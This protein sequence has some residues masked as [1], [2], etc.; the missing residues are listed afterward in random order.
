MYYIYHIE[1]VKIGCSINPT[2][3]VRQQG[4]KDLVILEEHTDIITASN[5]EL[6]LQKEFGYKVDNIQYHKCKYS[7]M[8]KVNNIPIIA[9]NLKSGIQKEYNSL[10][11]C[12]KEI[13]IG[14]GRITHILSPKY[15][16]KSSYGWTFNY[17]AKS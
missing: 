3:R 12:A 5:R 1:G 11:E 7:T 15:K 14:I 6:E 8:G 17:N 16:R 9:T 4:Y 10:T 2:L 13:G